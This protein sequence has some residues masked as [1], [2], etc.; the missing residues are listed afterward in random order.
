M[1]CHATLAPAAVPPCTAL[2]L[3][4]VDPEHIDL[5]NRLL[6]RRQAWQGRLGEQALRLELVTPAAD[7]D[8]EFELPLL[9]GEAAASVRLEPAL[10]QRLLAPLALQRPFASLPALLQ[11]VLLEQALLP[12]LEPLEA[13]L[14]NQLTLVARGQPCAL[15]IGLRLTLDEQ[16]LG[17]LTL[18]LST[19]AA[20][21]VAELLERHLPEAAHGLPALRLPVR[22]EAGRQHLSL[23]ELR[24]LNPGDVV[25]LD[26]PPAADAR[27]SLAERWQARVRREDDGLRLL[28]ALKPINPTRE[29]AMRPDADEGQLDDVPLQVVCQLGSLELSLA[30]LRGLGEGSVLPLPEQDGEVVELVVNGRCVGRGE[31][32]AIGSGLGVRLTRFASL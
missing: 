21:R 23:A 27:L 22:L 29:N 32:V 6:R 5:H 17:S 25:M 24:S 3:P 2:Q 1:T 18:A 12:L 16:P 15:R 20:E 28:D 9:L 11:G 26:T 7:A 31:L 30:Q 8:G 13:E 10:L 19:A 14:G 4:R